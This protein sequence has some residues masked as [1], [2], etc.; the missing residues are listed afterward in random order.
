MI[1]PGGG[2]WQRREMAAPE[3]TWFACSQCGLLQVEA[4]ACARCRFDPLIDVRRSSVRDLLVE[5]DQR[6]LDRA[7]ARNRMIGVVLG[8]LTIGACWFIPGFWKVRAHTIALPFLA[9][10]LLLMAVVGLGVLTVLDRRV[11]KTRF[12]WLETLP[13]A[14]RY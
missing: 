1:A 13:P 10:Q 5:T 2:L 9:D 7:S 8:M 6:R 3:A 14:E 4:P 11:P 12:P